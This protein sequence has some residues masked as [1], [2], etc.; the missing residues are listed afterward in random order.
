MIH[1]G[2]TARQS[3]KLSAIGLQQS[4]FEKSRQQSF[5]FDGIASEFLVQ[6]C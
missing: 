5:D 4:A 1:H 2:T 6:G 3:R